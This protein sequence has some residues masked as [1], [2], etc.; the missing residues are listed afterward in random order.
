MKILYITQGDPARTES[1]TEQRTYRL[2][3][4]LQKMGDVDVVGW[5]DFRRCS[6]LAAIFRRLFRPAELPRFFSP[7]QSEKKWFNGYD[8]VVTRYLNTAVRANAWRIA[9]CR[10]DI[11]DLPSEA[12]RTI[13]SKFW[14]WGFRWLPVLVVS[15]WEKWALKKLSGAWVANNCDVKKVSDS[16]PCEVFENEPLPPSEGYRAVGRQERIL[17]TIGRVGYPPNLDGICWFVR[18]VWREIGKRHPSWEYHVAGLG[19]ELLPKDVKSSGVK[20]LG[21]VRDIDALYEKTAGVVAPVFAGAGTSIKVREALSRERVVFSTSFA[22]R[23]VED[24]DNIV[25]CDT[26]EQM[27]SSIDKWIASFEKGLN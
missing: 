27:I 13:W 2:W 16:C 12:C 7:V 23:G 22:G 19:G 21:F 9:P 5:G 6:I 15:V 26:A 24:A 10:V 17:M 4:R 20:V 18:N 8:L 11:D 25:L 1:G 14:P 3:K